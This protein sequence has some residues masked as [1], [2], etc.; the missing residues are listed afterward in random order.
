MPLSWNEIKSRAVAFS[1]EWKNTSRE[2][3]DAK[4]FLIEFLHIFGI[5]QK[6]VATFEHRVRKINDSSGYIDLLWPGTLLVEMKSKG[7]DLEKAYQQAKQYCHG[8]KDYELPKL[9]LICD[10]HH[11]HI[12]L[13]NGLMV[14]FELPQ[15]IENLQ[16]FEELAGYQKRTYFEQ[17]PVNIAAAELMGKL[18]DQLKD[19]GYTG[20]A[21]EAYLVRLL[22]I[23]FADDSTIFQKG[24][25]FDYLEQR[26]N[27]DGSDL[28]M[29]LDQL[30]Q[31]LDTPEDKR[32][33][34]LDEQL[35]Q[36]PYVN[37]RLFSE[38]LPTAAFNTEMRRI[39]LDSCK[40]DWGKIS[41]AIFGS[42]F[43]S[44][45][46]ST[47]RRNLGAHYTSE[48]NI[49]KLIKPLFLDE[50]W[51]EFHAAGENH[52][53]LKALHG[54]ISKLRFLDPACGCGNFLIT[55]YRELRM[56]ELAIVEKLLNGQMVTNINQYFLV[57]LDQF[58]GI[59]L[60]EFPSQIAQ[61]AMFL[62]DHQCNMM[63]SDR[64]GEYIPLI[65]L[66]KSAIIVNENA[67]RLDWHSIIKPLEGEIAQPRFH[68]ILGN[69]PFVGK[70]EQTTIQKTE[71]ETLFQNIDGSGL[72]DYVTG[73]YIKAATYLDA[74]SPIGIAN[75]T[76]VAFVSTNSICQ[77]EQASVLWAQLSV[78]HKII[79]HFAHQTFK[80]SNE[81]KGVAAV[82]CVI[83]GFS[84]VNKSDKK[85][86]SY[87][88]IKGE[89]TENT[90]QNINCYLAPA[91]DIFVT[92][93]KTSISFAPDMNYGSMPIDDGHLVIEDEVKRELEKTDPAALKFIRPYTG[94]DEFINKKLR[95]CL[96]IDESELGSTK[97]S[98]FIQE[99]ITATR[100]FRL[101][102][103][104]A[105]TNK[106]AAYPAFFGER[107]QPVN[108]YLI[109]PKVSS[110]TR[111]FIPIGILQPNIIASG[112]ALIIPGATM[113]HFGILTSTM[114]NTWM[115]YVCGRMKSDYQYSA[116][117]VYNNYPW[118]EN[119]S[120][121]QKQA[122]EEAAQ[123]VL[124]AREQF[125][126]S[127]LADLYDP[128][129]MP[130]S[131]V[132]AHQVLDKSVDNCYRSQPFLTEA[133]R[134]EYLFELYDSYTAGLFVKIK[135]TPK[136]KKPKL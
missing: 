63:V 24:I 46:D 25:F 29:H 81:A 64:F 38:R 103:K 129:T 58:Y 27:E 65:P 131:L 3:A 17:D 23:L 74:Y 30:F 132:K 44:V 67:L 33:K 97:T 107:R 128:N 119:P 90:V 7:Q 70:K 8:L 112:S 59:E 88:N 36:F 83:V 79:I 16:I 71:I 104:R 21:L 108:A 110:E 136:S 56:L 12:Y 77:G 68:F 42:L 5:S 135:K 20:A 57:D 22:F 113:Y 126:K 69:P 18:H 15:L 52:N 125:P 37:G 35:N 28:A 124:D 96:W 14:Q 91:K 102:S 134:I 87:N 19:I 40:L 92:G 84:N 123:A 118:P 109:I 93:R 49:M 130:P 53:K 122:V 78:K 86:Y 4:P 11:F 115:R 50:L 43:Q 82:H 121:K 114:H 66:Q 98:N 133:K 60:G 32:L 62:I 85:L 99:R 106:L 117:I 80:W 31:I 39:L 89:P 111:R 95:W 55:A 105:T 100:E 45:M 54:K 61:V 127:S 75:P 73:W 41:P 51:E 72:L 1:N 13:D 9:I 6:R 34:T 48:N 94:G 2:E 120:D 26:T 101:A 116:S 47:A 10:F 76:R